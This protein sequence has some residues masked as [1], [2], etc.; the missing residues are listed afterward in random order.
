V[1]SHTAHNIRKRLA[2][3]SATPNAGGTCRPARRSVTADAQPNQLAAGSD[4]PHERASRRTFVVVGTGYAGTEVAAHRFLFTD[5]LAERH[6]AVGFKPRW[7]LVDVADRV[8]IGCCPGLAE[9]MS[10]IAD[11][12]LRECGVEVL[13]KTSVKDVASDGAHA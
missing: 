4:D 7:L 12:V 3:D 10:T 11:K 8:Q 6:C 1:Q 5:Q 9:R 2:A 13:M